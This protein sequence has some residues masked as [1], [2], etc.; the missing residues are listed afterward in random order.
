MISSSWNGKI[1]EIHVKEGDLVEG[2]SPLCAVLVSDGNLLTL[3]FKYFYLVLF[4][5]DELSDVELSTAKDPKFLGATASYPL[6]ERVI[7]AFAQFLEVGREL[8]NDKARLDFLEFLENTF[9]ETCELQ[10]R[11]SV[12]S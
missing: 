10:Y 1:S 5:I 11:H 6:E 7:K 3:K 8:A 9:K 2:G 12:L 4:F